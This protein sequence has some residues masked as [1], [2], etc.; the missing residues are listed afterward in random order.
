VHS[1]RDLAAVV[2]V[3]ASVT[4]HCA[5]SAGHLRHGACLYQRTSTPLINYSIHP[6]LVTV[7]SVS[8]STV[9]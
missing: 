3:V 9:V 5:S 2:A 7:V 1:G 6:L 4:W 8:I